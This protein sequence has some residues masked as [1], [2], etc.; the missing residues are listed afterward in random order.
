MGQNQPSRGLHF[1]KP[2][3]LFLF[4][5]TFRFYQVD[6]PLVF[7]LGDF[8]RKGFAGLLKAGKIPEIWKVAALLRLDGLHGAVVAVQKN[9]P[10]VRFFLQSQPAAIPAQPRELLDEIRFAQAFERGKPGNF[11]VRQS[12]LPWPAAA[13]RATLTFEE[14]RHGRV[15][16]PIRPF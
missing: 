6:A 16:F 12:H 9:A 8:A 10:A 5:A 15:R 13:G 3:Y 1:A 4:V 7:R 2:S 14:N 11:R